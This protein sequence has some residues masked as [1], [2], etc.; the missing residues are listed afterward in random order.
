MVL[1][2][3]PLPLHDLALLLLSLCFLSV[4][5]CGQARLS[6][7]ASLFSASL[8]QDWVL[9]AR[10]IAHEGHCLTSDFCS[11]KGVQSNDQ[12]AQSNNVQS[13][14]AMARPSV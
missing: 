4:F 13:K 9:T 7:P 11:L 10:D 2:W 12:L 5:S 1:V 14:P 8:C 6:D 3:T